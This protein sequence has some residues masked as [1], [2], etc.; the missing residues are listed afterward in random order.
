MAPKTKLLFLLAA[1]LL[2]ISEIA[3]QTTTGGDPSATEVALQNDFSG[4][5]SELATGNIET[6]DILYFPGESPIANTPDSLEKG[7]LYKLT[8]RYPRLMYRKS[9]LKELQSIRINLSHNAPD[10][11]LA[12]IFYDK[13][14]ARR[15]SLYF[16][17]L[18]NTGV[19][20]SPT[21]ASWVTFEGGDVPKWFK[22]NYAACLH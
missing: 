20:S 1:I 22:E 15:L 11:K 7:Y 6:M 12:L 5:V 17:L 10:V 13:T 14:Q 18:D 2:R 9:L 4:L 21:S 8:V 16:D 3:A 19:V